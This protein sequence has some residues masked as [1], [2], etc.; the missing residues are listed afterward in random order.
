MD[1]YDS[2]FSASCVLNEQVARQIFEILPEE[3]PIM[4][5]IDREGHSWTS[6]TEKF[7]ELNISES[8]LKELCG[9]IDDGDEPVISQVDNYSIIAA[10][11]TTNRTNCGYVVFALPQY[12]PESTLANIDLID[13]LINQINLIAKLIE[14][15]NLLYEFQMKQ[16]SIYGQNEAGSN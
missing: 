13:M 7:S 9:K 8:F 12:V 10:Q 3:G 15:N 16:M 1:M 2:L 6:N 14:N 4:V 5:I 11:L